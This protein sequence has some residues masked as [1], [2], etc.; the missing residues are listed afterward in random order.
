M[1][2]D[3]LKKLIAL[4]I[5]VYC[6]VL[7]CIRCHETSDERIHSPYVK[8]SSLGEL[9]AKKRALLNGNQK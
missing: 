4:R 6:V 2:Y 9:V 1:L 7:Y 3:L 8:E 5:V